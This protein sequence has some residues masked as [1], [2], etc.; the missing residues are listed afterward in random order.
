MTEDSDLEGLVAFLRSVPGITGT[1]GQGRYGDGLWWVKFGID[2]DHPLAWNVVQELGYV[3]N[4]ISVNERLP[5]AFMP[6]SPAPYLNG[7]PRQF[8]SWIIESKPQTFPR[9]MR[10]DGRR[11]DFHGRLT[12][13][14]S[15]ELQ[16]SEAQSRSRMVG[17]TARHR[18]ANATKPERVEQVRLLHHPPC[19]RGATPRGPCCNRQPSAGEP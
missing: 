17:R 9:R 7:G 6:V 2:I 12:I 1:I 4:Y 14:P 13:C 8:L 19:G 15:G 5:T 16:R 11:A 10:R 18:D 3:L